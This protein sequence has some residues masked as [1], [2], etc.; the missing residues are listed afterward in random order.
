VTEV[1]TG[2]EVGLFALCRRILCSRR[3]ARAY[4]ETRRGR[5]REYL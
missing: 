5:L 4:V 3:W 2:V 1:A